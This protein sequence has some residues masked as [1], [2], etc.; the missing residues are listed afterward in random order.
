MEPRNAFENFAEIVNESARVSRMALPI[1]FRYIVT[2][3]SIARQR[4]G[5]HIP[6]TQA[7]NNRTSIAR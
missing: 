2:C 1:N 6:A 4:V 5:K 3:I 7:L